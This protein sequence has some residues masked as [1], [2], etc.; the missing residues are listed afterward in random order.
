[1]NRSLLFSNGSAIVVGVRI[2][3]LT[4]VWI[5]LLLLSGVPL[6]A[7]LLLAGPVL[8]LL[9]LTL[10]AELVLVVHGTPLCWGSACLR[11][12]ET[13]EGENRSCVEP[14]S[15]VAIDAENRRIIP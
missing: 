11:L 9:L 15:G 7:A 13:H 8:P 2:D 3:V 12:H 5:L 1:M 4:L 14:Y 10:I 6:A